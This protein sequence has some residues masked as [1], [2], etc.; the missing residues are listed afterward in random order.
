MKN[1]SP[2]SIF[3]FFTLPTLVLSCDSSSYD[4]VHGCYKTFLNFYNMTVGANYTLPN[5]ELFAV[6]RGEFEVGKTTE[7]MKKVCN[8][9]NSLVSCLGSSDSCINGDDMSKIFYFTD[10]DN[11]MYTSDYYIA[12]YECTTA[13]N[14]TIGQFNCISTIGS[15]GY[16][17]LSDCVDKL[18]S[19]IKSEGICKAQIDYTT[20]LQTVYQSYCGLE[21][22]NYI[23]NIQRIGLTYELP[24][25]INELPQC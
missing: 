8:I 1:L 19:D 10:E 9:Q 25:C 14:V 12:N 20:C 24:Q 15:I 21:A 13:Y 6:T 2:I 5:Y 18:M 23:C 16:S 3:I 11:L 22:G 17:A 7:H 4:Q